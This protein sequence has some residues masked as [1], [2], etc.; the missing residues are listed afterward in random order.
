MKGSKLFSVFRRT[1]KSDRFKVY[2]S[3][4]GSLR[5]YGSDLIRSAAWRAKVKAL[6]DANLTGR[7][8]H[9]E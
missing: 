5:V 9:N 1:N 7:E 2:V 6:V 4:Q 3:D 8:I